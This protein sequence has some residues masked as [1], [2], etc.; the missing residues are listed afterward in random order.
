LKQE[1]SRQE[2]RYYK[3]KPKDAKEIMG[4]VLGKLVHITR[5]TQFLRSCTGEPGIALQDC[6]L[7]SSKRIEG[8]RTSTE[9]LM[10]FGKLIR[11]RLVTEV[12]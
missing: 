1:A 3:N 9:I 4:E 10:V 7:V 5:L 8:Y 12:R 6:R 2:K 11:F